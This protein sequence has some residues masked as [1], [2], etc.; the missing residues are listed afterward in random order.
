M[1]IIADIGAYT[2]LLTAR[3]PAA[4]YGCE[5]AA[6]PDGIIGRGCSAGRDCARRRA[7]LPRSRPCAAAAIQRTG[8]AATRPATEGPP[9]RGARRPALPAATAPG[10]GEDAA[11]ARVRGGA[12]GLKVQSA[13]FHAVRHAVHCA[14]RCLRGGDGRGD[15]PDPARPDPRI[16]DDHGDAHSGWPHRCCVRSPL[17]CVPPP[18]PRRSRPV[19]ASLASQPMS[20]FPDF[21]A[22]QLPRQPFRGLLRVHSRCG[23]HGRWAALGDPFRRSALDDVVTSIIRSDR[24]RLERQLPGGIRTR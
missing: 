8:R 3:A 10:R 18:I 14:V 1:R 11:R 13:A 24:Y 6:V 5:G 4:G 17:P 22:G 15:E 2:M 7:G 19:L 9:A 20:A 23:P 21:R 12:G 16:A